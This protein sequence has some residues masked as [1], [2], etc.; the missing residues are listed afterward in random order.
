MRITVTIHNR[1]RHVKRALRGIRARLRRRY[2]AFTLF[3]L[4][5]LGLAEPLLC[6][7]HCQIWVPLAFQSYFGMHHHMRGHDHMHMMMSMG[8][9]SM[10][11]MSMDSATMP[12][13]AEMPGHPAMASGGA[14]LSLQ[15][16]SP[17]QPLCAMRGGANPGSA[18][19]HVPPSPVHDILPALLLL[20]C[21]SFLAGARPAAPP[22]DPPRIF[23]P[24]LL[25]PPLLSAM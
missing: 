22:G 5:A 9:T 20:I 13:D 24:P 11:S 21:V 15:V 8:S 16:D 10:D 19:F 3:A 25:R 23:H 14:A 6:I 17:G 7:V 2:A 1:W 18:P 12:M 4:L